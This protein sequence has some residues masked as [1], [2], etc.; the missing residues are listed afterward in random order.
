MVK[1]VVSG[2]DGDVHFW[3]DQIQ[4]HRREQGKNP[5]QTWRWLKHL[6]VKQFFPD[7]YK[8]Y[9]ARTSQAIIRKKATMME[10]EILFCQE[11]VE[12]K[13]E[14]KNREILLVKNHVEE[15]LS[16]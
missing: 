15:D 2:L 9:L 3:W 11:K 5:I 10:T 8:L 1:M 4:D 7:F 6:I 14:E 12:V 13:V 16:S